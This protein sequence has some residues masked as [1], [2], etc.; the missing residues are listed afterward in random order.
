MSLLAL[1]LRGVTRASYSATQGEFG[2]KSLETP[3]VF[4]WEPLKHFKAS[5]RSL[6]H[7]AVPPP[8]VPSARSP[9]SVLHPEKDSLSSA[10]PGR[11]P[12]DSPLCTQTREL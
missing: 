2:P 12:P 4:A 10:P 11:S 7:S 3:V 5:W 9:R 6:L 8:I 1:V